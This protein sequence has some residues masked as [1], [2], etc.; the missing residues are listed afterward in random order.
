M[1]G[2]SRRL[3]ALVA[4]GLAAAALAA[5]GAQ[6]RQVT[7]PSLALAADA[8]VEGGL[9]VRK[10]VVRPA[11]KFAISKPLRTLRSVPI[12]VANGLETEE[13]DDQDRPGGP[14]APDPVVQNTFGAGAPPPLGLSFNGAESIVDSRL[15]PPDTN[16]DVGPKNYVEMV[17]V[18]MEVFDKTGKP[19]YGPV[20][21]QTLFGPLGKQCG[22][23]G[24]GD[25]V[26]VYDQLA[27][28]WVLSQF[29]FLFDTLTGAPT[30]PFFECIAVSKTSDPTGQYYLYAF[31]ISDGKLNDYP[32]LGVWPDAYYMSINQFNFSGFSESYG[33][34]G[35]VAFDR[36]AMLRGD[37]D[38]PMVY[39]DLFNMNPDFGGM[40]P[41][42]LDGMRLPPAGAPNI[43][44]QLESPQLGE[45]TGTQLELFRFHV[46]WDKPANSSFTRSA[47]LPTASFDAEL[48]P[49]GECVKQKTSFQTLDTLSDRLMFRLAYRNFGSYDALVLN[50]TVD[51]DGQGKGGIRWYEIRNALTGTPTIFQQSTFAPDANSRWMGSIAMDGNGDIGLGYS[52]SG[53][54]LYPSIRYTGRLATDP[55]GQM[56]LGEGSIIEGGG[57]ATFVIGR[58]GDYTD[59]TVDPVDDCTFWYANEYYKQS[60]EFDWSTRIGTFMIPG[61]DATAPTATVRPASGKAGKKVNLRY[62]TADN[63][64]Q[65][66]ETITILRPNGKKF[67]T[68]TTQLHDDGSA[69][70][71]V[72][73]P[74][75]AG[76]YNFCVKPTDGKGNDGKQVCAPFN[77][78]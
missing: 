76:H 57:A 37:P 7:L 66:K 15:T 4:A 54:D 48:C 61:C 78:A 56:T 50:H 19:L 3:V 21:L 1:E 47:T 59:L 26:V 52:V 12:D 70:V 62:Q 73:A 25:P 68:L 51:A 77:V 22:V 6:A 39:Y 55:P 27:D 42:D 5:A 9:V 46:D 28:R 29:G 69:F 38:A 35:A 11:F 10:P 24:V 8:H 53:T 40:L 23:S 58:W 41:T 34:A 16:G 71:T 20:T 65:T 2:R 45:F 43:F 18:Q 72:K 63:S 31:K 64:G 60:S 67:K 14:A 49:G 44:V 74:K 33:G 17:N 13:R 32:K 75:P 36:A 30:G